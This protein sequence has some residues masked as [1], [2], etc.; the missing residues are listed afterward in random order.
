VRHFSTLRQ[1]NHV[2]I[3]QPKNGIAATE[4]V[5]KISV[6]H[7]QNDHVLVANASTVGLE[8]STFCFELLHFGESNF[9]LAQGMGPH[10]APQ[11]TQSV[12]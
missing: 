4:Q 2:S 1:F 11:S 5:W 7:L 9:G 10:I 6:A 12:L 8:I 3:H